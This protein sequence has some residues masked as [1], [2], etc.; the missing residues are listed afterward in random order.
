MV[1]RCSMPTERAAMPRSP[2][3]PDEESRENGERTRFPDLH[4]EHRC[5]VVHALVVEGGCRDLRQRVLET[6]PNRAQVWDARAQVPAWHAARLASPSR[7][8]DACDA[9]ARDALITRR[10]PA[11][12]SSRRPSGAAHR[13][14]A[15]SASTVLAS[16]CG[17]WHP[18]QESETCILHLDMPASVR[19]E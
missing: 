18:Q 5:H 8:G 11:R 12:S 15:T 6:C 17:V 7:A 1:A 16:L 3:R 14:R 2:E 19:N 9:A 13:D 10:S 4:Q